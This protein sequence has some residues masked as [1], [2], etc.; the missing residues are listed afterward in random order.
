MEVLASGANDERQ[1]GVVVAFEDSAA[2]INANTASFKWVGDGILVTP[3]LVK[4]CPPP[5]RRILGNLN[6]HGALLRALDLGGE[7]A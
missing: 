4:V 7:T 6:D 2:R 1:P 3:M 5:E